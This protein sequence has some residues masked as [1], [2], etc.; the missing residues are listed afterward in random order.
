MRAKVALRVLTN[1]SIGMTL[2]INMPR[3]LRFLAF[4]LVHCIV[5]DFFVR[6][7]ACQDASTRPHRE[8]SVTHV[9][10]DTPD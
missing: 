9:C 8:E 4:F 3:G 1:L 6:R 7:L 10:G 2:A 5:F